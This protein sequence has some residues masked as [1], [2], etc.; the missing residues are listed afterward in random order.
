V[1]EIWSDLTLGRLNDRVAPDERSSESPFRLIIGSPECRDS[2]Q[3]TGNHSYRSDG[4]DGDIRHALYRF[5]NGGAAK[6][7]WRRGLSSLFSGASKSVNKSKA[8]KRRSGVRRV[9]HP[10]HLLR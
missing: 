7:V 2:S 9:V 6:D 4:A 5:N 8:G 10:S 3:S 1:Y